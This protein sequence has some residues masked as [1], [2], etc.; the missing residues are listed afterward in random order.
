TDISLVQKPEGVAAVGGYVYVLSHPGH[1]V[2]R[3][4]CCGGTPDVSNTLRRDSQSGVG[5]PSGLAIYGDYMWVVVWGPD[6]AIYG[7]LLDDAFSGTGDINATRVIP[8]LT[9][10]NSVINKS[11]TGLAIDNN[12]Y[13]YVLDSDDTQFYQYP[14]PGGPYNGD[15][16]VASN[17]LLD[18]AGDPLQNPSGAMFDGTSLWVVDYGTDTMYQYNLTDLFDESGTTTP[19][20]EF[21]LDPANGNASGV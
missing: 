7:Y 15:P 11:P 12:N 17:L 2:Y 21:P 8:L 13:I 6:Y 4:S 20:F 10:G 18:T 19:I 5:N 3:Y 16:V 14:I 1:C 9:V